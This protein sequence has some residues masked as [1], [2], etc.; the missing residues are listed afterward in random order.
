MGTVM[1]VVTA[2]GVMV[3]L[4]A[5]PAYAQQ[6]SDKKDPLTLQY[7]AEQRRKAEIEKEYDATLKRTRTTVPETKSDPWGSVRPAPAPREKR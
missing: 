3:A 7:E 5:G 1:R 6:N 2:M 4:I